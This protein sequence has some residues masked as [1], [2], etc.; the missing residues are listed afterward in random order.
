MCEIETGGF[1]LNAKTLRH[2]ECYEPFDLSGEIASQ[3]TN[4]G[5][6]VLPCLLG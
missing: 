2:K 1:D 4:D 3:A 6:H 5:F